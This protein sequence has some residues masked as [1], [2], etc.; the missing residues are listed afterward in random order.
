[1]AYIFAAD[2]IWVFLHSDVCS[3]L[4]KTL[5]FCNIVHIGRSRSISSYKVDDFGTD[6]KRICDFLLVVHCK[7]GLRLLVAPFLRYAD[8]L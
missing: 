2:C 1:M 7:Y 8:L 5:R 4:Q 6:R 3:G